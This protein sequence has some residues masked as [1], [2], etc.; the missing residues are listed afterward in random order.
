MLVYQGLR[1]SVRVKGNNF[2]KLQR[3]QSSFTFST[4]KS[5]LQKEQPKDEKRKSRKNVGQSAEPASEQSSKKRVA[6]EL[7]GK[8]LKTDFSWLPKAPSTDHL[9]QRDVSTTLLYSGYRPFVLAPA[10]QKQT[11]STLYEFAM[12]LE[13]LGDPLPWISSATGTEFYGE[14]DGVPAD[15]IKQLRPFQPPADDGASKDKKARKLLQKGILEAEK[16][17]LLNRSK[18]RKRPILKL[19]QL[20]KEFEDEN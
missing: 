4:N 5:L 11:D 8:Q 2:P 15:V 13:S 14:W 12:K 19:L 16:K 10:D 3:F 7:K 18:G 6:V 9:K 20:A 1:A 17:K